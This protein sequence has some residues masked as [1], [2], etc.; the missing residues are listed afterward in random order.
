MP[1]VLLKL[2]NCHFYYDY[3]LQILLPYYRC[4]LQCY[5]AMKTVLNSDY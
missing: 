1:H 2:N 3:Y 4:E 5:T